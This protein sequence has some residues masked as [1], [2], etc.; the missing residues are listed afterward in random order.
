[1]ERNADLSGIMKEY[2]QRCKTFESFTE[3]LKKLIDNLLKE[4][5]INVLSVTSRTKDIEDIKKTLT[6]KEKKVIGLNEIP[7][8]S[9]LRIITFFADDVDA[10]ASTI[11]TEFDI[12]KENSVDKRQLLDP[13]RFGYLSLHYVVRL[14]AS[15]KKLTEY[16]R[17]KDCHAEV[18]IRSILQHA[19]AEIEHD[20]GYKSK[21][22]VPKDIRRRFS[23]LA[24]LLEVADD[25]FVSIRDNLQEYERELPMLI[26]GAPEEVLIDKASLLS[27]IQ[28]NSLV[29]EIDRIIANSVGIQMGE[30]VH[31][32]DPLMAQLRYIDVKNIAEL[33]ALLQ[34]EKETIPRFAKLWFSRYKYDPSTTT[35]LRGI[36]VVYLS[37]VS[38]GSTQSLP[39]AK[40]FVEIQ[41]DGAGEDEKLRKAQEI[42]SK[43]KQ[44]KNHA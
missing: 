2:E 6:R 23:R 18:Q 4:N 8:I 13:D 37:Y 31:P 38:V 16:R 12:D 26:A 36:C 15:R 22:A 11:E 19:W 24:G 30:S 43:Y 34:R 28:T 1:M 27:F 44:I 5:R 41:P 9:G 35:A 33:N 21:H 25:E 32:L 3:A 17:F 10:V 29:T 40:G 7:D 42:L 39:N 20:L 14:S